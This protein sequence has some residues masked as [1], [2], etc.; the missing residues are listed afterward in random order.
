VRDFAQE[1][2]LT[3][4]ILLDQ[5]SQAAQTFRVRGIPTSFFIDREG[6]VRSKHT[7]PLNKSLIEE[8]VEPLLP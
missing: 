5:S 7:G 2:G 1:R 6:V 8:N 4:T 3:F